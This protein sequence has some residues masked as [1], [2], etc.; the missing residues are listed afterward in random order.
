MSKLLLH[1]CC[2]PCAIMPILNLRQA[3]FEV[4]V[5]FYNPNIHPLKEYLRRRESLGLLAEKL[6]LNVI[7]ND[8]YD[9]EA[10]LLNALDKKRFSTRCDYCYSV[11]LQSCYDLARSGGFDYFSSSL[12]Y[13][14]RQNH[15]AICHI[16]QELEANT[17][18]DSTEKK[19]KFYYQDFRLGWQEG[20][21]ISKQYGLYRQNYC[22]CVLS[23]NERFWKE[24]K[25]ITQI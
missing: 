20:I 15:S 18:V 21:D 7:Y 8:D 10:W 23:E 24:Y 13:S 11:R 6:E 19:T 4:S 5:Y 1:V 2:G 25:K 22:G 16:A 9:T 14:I 17:L 3:G 12:L